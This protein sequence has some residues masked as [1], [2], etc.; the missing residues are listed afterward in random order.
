[1]GVGECLAGDLKNAAFLPAKTPPSQKIT[2]KS[3]DLPRWAP[4]AVSFLGCNAYEG[5]LTLIIT[6][7]R[8]PTFLSSQSLLLPSL[9]LAG[10]SFSQQLLLQSFFA[11]PL[12]T[13]CS[14][15]TYFTLLS[16]LP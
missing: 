3:G 15:S 12:F 13:F 14:Y 8:S 1:M 4:T 5:R 10:R 11:L 9:S 6:S 16:P 2:S 7:E